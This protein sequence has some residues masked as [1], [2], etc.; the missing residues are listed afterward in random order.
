M[1]MG[2]IEKNLLSDERIIFKTRKHLIIFFFPVLV[3]IFAYYSYNY[4]QINSILNQLDW[5]PGAITLLFWAYTGLEYRFSE[6]AVTNKRV[7]MREGFFVRHANELRLSAISQ[8]NI[9]QSII[10]QILGYGLVRINAFGAY[11]DYPTIANPN[12]FQRAVNEQM[13]KVVR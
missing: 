10:G 8:V 4:M 11:D 12:G 1:H 3:T 6:F 7:M 5:I 13:D 9:D 2:Y